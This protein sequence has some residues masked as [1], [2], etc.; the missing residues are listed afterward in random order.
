MELINVCLSKE[1]INNPTINKIKSEIQKKKGADTRNPGTENLGI[2]HIDIDIQRN[3][4]LNRPTTTE[5]GIIKHN[6]CGTSGTQSCFRL[7]KHQHELGNINQIDTQS[8][9]LLDRD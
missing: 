4:Q 2:E 6:I 5:F 8:N 7:N 9:T 1:E 3:Q